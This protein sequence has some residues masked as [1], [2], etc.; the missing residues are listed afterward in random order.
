MTRSI[1]TAVLFLSLTGMASAAQADP[2]PALPP[3]SPASSSPSSP[4]SPP[5]PP[6]ELPP[7]PPQ[8]DR[9]PAPAS[10]GQWVYTGQYGWLW[11][12]YGDQYIDTP[13]EGSALPPDE[14]AY[15]PAYGWMW[16]SAPWVWGWG[17]APFYGVLGPSH[18]TWF[19]AGG[20]F[21]HVVPGRRA[22]VGG[23]GAAFGHARGGRR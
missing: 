10:S 5:S 12:P 22:F 20:H 4:S 17:V 16:V 1:V 15:D 8:Q 13:P 21:V 3:S 9:A 7:P 11:M 18:F 23:H 14:Y 2:A 6:A 19:R